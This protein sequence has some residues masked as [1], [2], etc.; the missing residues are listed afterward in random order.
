MP[1]KESHMG[2]RAVWGVHLPV[3][4]WYVLKDAMATACVQRAR[5]KERAREREVVASRER[6]EASR[7]T[8]DTYDTIQVFTVHWACT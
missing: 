7:L 6:D 5:E 3:V 4:R 2:E 1:G 8:R